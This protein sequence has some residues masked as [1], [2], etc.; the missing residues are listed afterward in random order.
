MTLSELHARKVVSPRDSKSLH[1]ELTPTNHA[2][3][4]PSTNQISFPEIMAIVEKI[5]RVENDKR[6]VWLRDD[7][8]EEPTRLTINGKMVNI[9]TSKE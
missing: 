5:D 2:R 1:Q 3:N 9:N 8:K 4:Q 7:T 6:V